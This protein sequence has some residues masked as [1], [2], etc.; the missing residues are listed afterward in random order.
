MNLVA[1]M[2]SLAS[3]SAGGLRQGLPVTVLLVFLTAFALALDL[4][5]RRLRFGRQLVYLFLPAGGIPIVLLS[6]AFFE[7]KPVMSFMPVL[8]FLLSLGLS[9]VAVVRLRPAWMTSISI[10][11]CFLWYGAWCCFIAGMSITGDWL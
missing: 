9:V 6:G 1:E 4:W 8:C 7:E 3:Q 5:R 11:L 2:I 10:S